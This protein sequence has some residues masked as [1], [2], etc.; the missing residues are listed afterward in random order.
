[1]SPIFPSLLNRIE[2]LVSRPQSFS[3]K[4]QHSL[5]RCHRCVTPVKSVSIFIEV[6]LKMLFTYPVMCAD[7]PGFQVGKHPMDMNH[8]KRNA[9]LVAETFQLVIAYPVIGDDSRAFLDVILDE[10][11]QGC[12]GDIWYHPE[13]YPVG[14]FPPDVHSASTLFLSVN[15]SSL[16]SIE[17]AI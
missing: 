11:H 10:F 5:K 7:E 3:S 2:S 17:L 6:C 12:L 8:P 1:M 16:P 15:N 13:P 9:M 4:P 14:I